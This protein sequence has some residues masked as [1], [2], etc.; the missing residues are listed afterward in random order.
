MLGQILD[1][2]FINLL[3]EIAMYFKFN[4]QISFEEYESGNLLLHDHNYLK[5][6]DLALADRKSVV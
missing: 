3:D 4:E 6:I 1:K 2:N 5:Y